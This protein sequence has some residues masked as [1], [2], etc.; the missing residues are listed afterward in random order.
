MSFALDA[1]LLLFASD[2]GSAVHDRALQVLDEI[3]LGPEIA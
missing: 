2:E 3:A 1:N